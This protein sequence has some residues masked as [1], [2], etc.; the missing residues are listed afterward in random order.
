MND[1]P[2]DDTHPAPTFDARSFRDALGWF[3]TGVTVITTVA[4]DGAPVGITANSFSSVSLDPPLVLFSLARKAYSLKAFQDAGRFAIN[5]LA[6]DQAKV[7]NRFATALTEKWQGLKYECWS[8]GCPMITGA[9]A[10]FDCVTHAM[11]DGGDHVIMVGRVL[12]LWRM[13][14]GEPLVFCRG[15]YQ[16][17]EPPTIE[18][19]GHRDLPVLP[20]LTGLDPWF[21]G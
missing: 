19:A 2:A 11:Y 21:S 14:E 17:L 5:V 3:A 8:S 7:S 18:Y 4:A 10:S 16:R 1:V 15:L 6:A 12:Q 13:G 9:L 20:P